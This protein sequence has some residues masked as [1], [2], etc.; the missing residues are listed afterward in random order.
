[1]VRKNS[2][3]IKLASIY[4]KEI[5]TGRRGEY[6]Y[7]FDYNGNFFWTFAEDFHSVF[8]MDIDGDSYGETIFGTKTG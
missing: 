5:V 3:K 2:Q 8:T 1:M 7:A 6:I 4:Y